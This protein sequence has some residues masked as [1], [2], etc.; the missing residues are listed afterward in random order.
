[1]PRQLKTQPRHAPEPT[2][3][4][5]RNRV[6][7]LG[8]SVVAMLVA[9]V[10]V[11]L[12]M[13]TLQK[14]LDSTPV[15]PISEVTFVGDMQRVDMAELK[16]VAGGIRGS[17]LQTNL[18]DVKAA[19]KQVRWVRNADVRR[20][21]PSTLE[22][23]LEE[24]R[25]YAKW[26]DG[27]AEQGFLVNTFGEVFE[28]NLDVALPI[29]SGPQG[30]SKDVL[31]NYAMFKSRLAVI[32]LAPLSIVLSARRAWQIRLD[33]GALL[34]LGRAEAGERLH[35]YV[36]AYPFVSA[37]KMPNLHIDMRYQSG[38]AVRIADANPTRPAAGAAP[39]STKKTTARS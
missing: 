10:L 30:T 14:N 1:M 32:G 21:F 12:A 16:R 18:N 7:V 31:A 36:S 2:A 11:W 34:E 4:F 3:H 27:D 24:H 13:A 5:T 33:N 37:L 35:R 38:M 17:M 15:F 23:S 26:K 22:I 39:K 29:F 20:R 19:I 28:A 8:A 9:A 25:P 6:V